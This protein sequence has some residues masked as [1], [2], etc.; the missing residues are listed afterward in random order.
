MLSDLKAESRKEI[1]IY[2]LTVLRTMLLCSYAPQKNEPWNFVSLHNRPTEVLYIWMGGWANLSNG[3]IGDVCWSP[4]ISEQILSKSKSNGENR[5]RGFEGKV[6]GNDTRLFRF[7]G[8][9]YFTLPYIRC[10]N[11]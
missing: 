8:K 4:N 2:R 10:K 1:H 5:D 7:L 3:R 6:I 9:F 11:L